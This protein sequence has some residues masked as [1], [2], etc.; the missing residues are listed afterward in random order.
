[1][2]VPFVPRN[3]KKSAHP[4]QSLIDDN[5]AFD[6]AENEV[7]EILKTLYDLGPLRDYTCIYPLKEE[8][9]LKYAVLQL[10][11]SKKMILQ[12][13][14]ELKQSKTFDR[15]WATFQQD[16]V[17]WRV[18]NQ[19]PCQCLLLPSLDEKEVGLALVANQKARFEQ[20]CKGLY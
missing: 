9:F 14:P 8:G 19:L 4:F 11:R 16:S 1:M 18:G 10:N 15:V 2:V 20:G 13:I 3:E 5:L 6:E 7:F 12:H 17:T